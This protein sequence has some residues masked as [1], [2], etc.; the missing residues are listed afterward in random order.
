MRDRCAPVLVGVAVAA[1]A[2]LSE[3]SRIRLRC[4]GIDLN[5]DLRAAR[6]AADSAV[7]GAV[8]L[9]DGLGLDGDIATRY[10][11]TSAPA[12]VVID[13]A[14]RIVARDLWHEPDWQIIRQEAEPWRRW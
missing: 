13:P 1:K 3:R 9:C 8:R 4:I 14:G 5:T 10:A 11:V 2:G 7:D 6:S 12:N